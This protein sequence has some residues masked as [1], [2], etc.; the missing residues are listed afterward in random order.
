MSTYALDRTELT[1]AI[2]TDS[3]SGNFERE[4]FS[5][6]TG[7]S[8]SPG[9][10]PIAREEARMGRE[11]LGL[12]PDDKYADNP[13]DDLL[14]IRIDDPGDDGY[15]RRYI[16][17]LPTPGFFNVH[18]THY[19]EGYTGEFERD[20][21]YCDLC[22]KAPPKADHPSYPAFQSVGF[23]LQREP[24]PEE[25]KLIKERT[26]LWAASKPPKTRPWVT[27][28]AILGFRLLKAAITW[29]SSDL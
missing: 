8:D 18:G 7:M 15:H 17:I 6:V 24:T 5:F 10:E 13:F 23:F 2:D 21:R 29:S 4:L 16:T 26:L 12:D 1:L 27:R 25:V 19:K 14:D 3:Y 28:P 9:D 22:K 11:A 20:S